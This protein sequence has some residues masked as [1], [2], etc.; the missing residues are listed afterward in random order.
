MNRLATAA[1]LVVVLLV[2]VGG[3]LI[4][5][6]GQRRTSPVSGSPPI[7][8]SFVP[9]TSPAPT[10]AESPRTTR[11]AAY[12][13]GQVRAP[14]AQAPQSKLWFADGRWWGILADARGQFTIHWL[15]WKTQAWN[16][17]RTLVDDRSGA[18]ADALWADGV[19]YV[20]SAGD[21]PT[22]P[23]DAVRVLR[24]SYDAGRARYTLDDGFPV[25]LAGGGAS[26]VTIARDG[27][28]RLWVS[29]LGGDGLTL[30]ASDGDDHRWTAPFR[31][32]APKGSLPAEA[33]AI[34][35][36]PDRVVLVWT[37]ANE[38]LLLSATHDPSAPPQQAWRVT[39]TAV[40]GLVDGPDQIDLKAAPESGGAVLVAVKTSLAERDGA[41][42]RDPQV[43]LLE[44]QTDGSWT[45]HVVSLITDRGNW[46]LIAIDE[47]RNEVIV[48][49]VSPASGGRVYFK[50]ASLDTLDF[51]VGIGAPFVASEQDAQLNRPTT[52]KQPVSSATGLVVVAADDRTGHYAHGAVGL[53]GAAPGQTAAGKS[54]TPVSSAAGVVLFSDTFDAHPDGEPVDSGWELSDPNLGTL[55][56]AAAPSAVDHS[57]RLAAASPE[58][59]ASAC[60][61][62]PPVDT[63]DL[64]LAAQVMV[65]GGP[66][67]DDAKIVAVRGGGIELV[68]VRLDQDGRLGYF[69]GP[70]RQDVNNAFDREAWFAVD[71]VIH[72]EQRTYDWNVTDIATGTRAGG[73]SGAAWRT[74]DRPPDKIC[75]STATGPGSGLLFDDV[76]VTR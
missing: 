56:V 58:L 24:F 13:P 67:T 14:T 19:L 53:G 18:R 61:A 54:T 71:V 20:V 40:D 30:V 8:S 60:R 10:A 49:C 73:T 2:A 64:H 63:G 1:V 37:A 51:G 47:E 36:Q 68:S 59:A 4:V 33:A 23:Q 28:S 11:G 42:P 27:F 34:V 46:P 35:A 75:F 39:P 52:T 17:T 3:A 16:D 22:N 6:N 69:N 66:A 32:T 29:Y 48:L 9:S 62:I 44:L 38:D 15:D 76:R 7:G 70:Q 26:N 50:T 55:T 72:L 25:V 41:N 57:A 5:A 65:F 43:L 31:P 74:T 12:D 45:Q 21:K